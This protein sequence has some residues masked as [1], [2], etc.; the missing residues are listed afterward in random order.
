MNISHEYTMRSIR[1]WYA[2]EW[3]KYQAEQPFLK[4]P[5]YLTNPLQHASRKTTMQ[6]YARNGSDD[7][8]EAYKRCLKKNGRSLLKSTK[9]IQAMGV[10]KV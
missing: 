3:I 4:E 9:E 7:R 8:E 5:K 1:C 10:A 2:T 6:Y